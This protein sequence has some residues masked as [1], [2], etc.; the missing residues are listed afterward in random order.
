MKFF[1]GISA[2]RK[3]IAV[4]V[5][6][7]VLAVGGF[8]FF[9]RRESPSEPAPAAF[10]PPQG[11]IYVANMA[12]NSILGFERNLDGSIA[13]TPVRIIRGPSTGL[14]NPFDVEIDGL[15]RIWVASLGYPPATNPR[16]T[17]YE[18]NVNGNAAP[19][20]TIQLVNPAEVFIPGALARFNTEKVLVS[21][22]SAG[23]EQPL[24]TA[25]NILFKV[26]N[27][28]IA[29]QR[30]F[31][32]DLFNSSGQIINPTG[33]AFHSDKMFVATS[34]RPLTPNLYQ[35]PNPSASAILIFNQTSDSRFNGLP[36]A[37]IAGN[38]TSLSNPAHMASDESGRL[39]VV[40]R[41]D[42]QN[43]FDSPGITVYE[44]GQTGN[45]T[46]VR[47]IQ[48]ENTRLNHFGD[49]YGIAV[50]ENGFIY[51]NGQNSIL[52]F[53]PDANGNVPP[54]HTLNNSP[55]SFRMNSDLT[56]PVGIAVR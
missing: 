9:D 51:V 36:S 5:L 45:A 49:N 31:F 47:R 2:K 34:S 23:F 22:V 27:A 4:T 29:Q 32:D 46:P 20:F 13:E 18:P 17:V 39:Y 44:Q 1:P 56:R 38:N 26:Q 6:V 52:V 19:S 50:D 40:N 7:A 24:A 55:A 53:A 43:R 15:N 16:I 37:T 41:G 10:V 42:P 48:G 14:H 35:V 28:V 21:G 54:L 8:L 12:D 25:P 33:I 30:I 11:E 3:I